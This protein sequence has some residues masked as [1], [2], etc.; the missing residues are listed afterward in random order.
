MEKGAVTKSAIS[1][2]QS[3]CVRRE[4][5][6]V[7]VMI[8][9]VETDAIKDKKDNRP[10]LHQKRRHGLTGR[11]PQKVQAGEERALLEKEERFRAEHS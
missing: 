4:T 8:E 1:G 3:D 2:K 10:L 5:H 9:N 7:S 6:V 11:Y